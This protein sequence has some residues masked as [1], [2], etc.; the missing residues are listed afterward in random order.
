[1]RYRTLGRTGLR[2]SEVAFGGG[3]VGGILIDPDDETKRDAFRRALAG[4]VNW[5]DTAPRYGDGRSEEALGWLL[6]ETEAVPHIST[7]VR[8]DPHRL[9]DIAGQIEDS[10]TA[11]LTRLERPGVDLLLLH[12]RVAAET[13]E[14]AIAMKHVLGKGGAA[15]GLERMRAQGLARFIGFTALGDGACCRRVAESDRFDAAQ[16]YYNMLNPSAGRPMPRGWSGQDFGGLME[17]CRA[18]DL[19]VMAIRVFAAGVI[20]IDRRTGRESPSA[21]DADIAKEERRTRAVFDAIGMEHG[22]RAQMALRFVLADPHVSCAIAGLSEISHIDEAL[23][24]VDMGPLPQPVIAQINNL[25][26]DNFGLSPQP[27]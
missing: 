13:G 12:N 3:Y 2:I 7:K 11:S 25:Y 19:G 10:L 27:G 20:A 23:A 24:A 5:V 16:V 4:G 1:M 15:D 26:A 18:Q 22:T 9:D 17:T 6:K 8:L 14:Q 21:E